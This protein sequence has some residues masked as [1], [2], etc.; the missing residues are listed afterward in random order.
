MLYPPGYE[1]TNSRDPRATIIKIA[2]E[3]MKT[4][5]KVFCVTKHFPSRK[6]QVGP[7]IIIE[8]NVFRDGFCQPRLWADYGG[9][10]SGVCLIFD[11]RKLDQNIQK[12]LSSKKCRIF[13]GSVKYNDRFAISAWGINN[14]E[15]GKYDAKS[16][17]REYF[18]QHYESCFLT[19]TSNWKSENEYRW[20]IHSPTKKPEYVSI[21][22][23]IKGVIVGADFPRVYEGTLKAL[24]KE[25]NIPAGRIQWVNGKPQVELE[26]IY[27]L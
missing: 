19:K 25:L 8:D 16:L 6:R 27:S 22:G 5:W 20:L 15:T 18:F 2:N 21:E 7:D 23:A 10:H 9:R 12:T 26:S 3:V 14:V 17:V 1:Y 24:C 13:Q 4:E 11:G